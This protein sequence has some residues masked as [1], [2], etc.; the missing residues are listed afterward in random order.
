[1]YDMQ[2]TGYVA[3]YKELNLILQKKLALGGDECK[4]AVWRESDQAFVDG[5]RDSRAPSRVSG[6]ML[7]AFSS[8]SRV[9]KTIMYS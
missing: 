7:P 4:R 6:S 5:C 2:I 9:F 8:S 1:M 3:C